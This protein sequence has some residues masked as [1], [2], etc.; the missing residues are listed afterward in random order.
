MVYGPEVAQSI[1]RLCYGLDDRGSNPGRSVMDF[2]SLLYR[3]QEGTGVHSV[4]YPMG[5]RGSYPWG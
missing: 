2:F 1:Y 4:A 5:N 3:V